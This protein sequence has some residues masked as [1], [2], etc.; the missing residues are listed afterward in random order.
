MMAGGVVYI[1]TNPCLA[2]WVKIGMTER[3]DVNKRIDELNRSSAIP[4]SFHLF[5]SYETDDAA[6][7]E[8]FIHRV[9]DEIDDTRRA[10]E[11]LENGKERVREFFAIDPETAYNILFAIADY[12]HTTEKLK[13]EDIS[14]NE[15]KEEV[16]EEKVQAQK[17]PIKRNFRKLGIPVGSTLVFVDNNSY[18]CT[19]VDDINQVR[20]DGDTF[21]ISTLAE[22]LYCEIRSLEKPSMN[23]F[24]HFLYNGQRLDKLPLLCL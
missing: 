20:Y 14:E 23:G 10:R 16:I 4:L 12:T 8:R 19:T 3:D 13:R 1:L 15:K 22:K 7:T 21:A 5:A 24:L 9:I 11:T 18:T 6:A 17:A 2:G